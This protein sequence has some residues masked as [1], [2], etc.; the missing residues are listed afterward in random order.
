LAWD[1]AAEAE[2]ARWIEHFGTQKAQGQ[3]RTL[4]GCLKKSNVNTLWDERD[5]SL[6]AFADCA[7]VPFVMRAYFSYKKGLPYS[8]A[9]VYGG[10]YTAGNHTSCAVVDGGFV[11]DAREGREL[12]QK[13]YSGINALL[14]G[15]VNRVMS[16]YLRTPPEDSAS[17][18]FPVD[19]SLATVKPGTLFYDPNGHVLTVFKVEADGTIRMFDGHPDQTLTTKI[20]GEMFARGGPKQ[21]GG[22]R[23][24]RPLEE[25]GNQIFRPSNQALVNRGLGYS[26]TAQ[27][28]PSSSYPEKN[29][30][31]WVRNRLSR[32]ALMN[33]LR[34]FSEK[35][36]QLCVDVRDRVEAV[37]IA[38]GAGVHLRPHPQ[39]LPPNIYGAEGDWEVYSTPSRDARLKASLREISRFVVEMRDAVARGDDSVGY[40]GSASQL[41]ADFVKSWMTFSA[42]DSC[43]AE[44]KSAAGARVR[45][46]LND[47]VDRIYDL[48][49]DPYHC[50]ELRWGAKP[51]MPE[52]NDAACSGGGKLHW[53]KIENTL[54]NAIDREYGAP[55]PI[56]WGPQ[57]GEPINV[58]RVLN[59]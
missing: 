46:G 16:G 56:G 57:T 34:E 43:S 1:N 59:F 28:L 9:T 27:Y 49:F 35:T 42:E 3:C 25:R 41:N 22:F 47:V 24:W 14:N 30:Y 19:V 6:R 44:Y 50:A 11:C 38:L 33:P 7:D 2:Y 18:T 21:G 29:Y 51:G 12:H 55:T 17:D 48:S 40:E 58:R 15:I 5:S 54:R 39:T 10:R 53:Y 45:L 23:N 20:F 8:L 26:A 37:N 32:G 52:Y 4:E 36:K 31:K 13:N